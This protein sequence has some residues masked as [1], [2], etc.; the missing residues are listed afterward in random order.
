MTLAAVILLFRCFKPKRLLDKLKITA[1]G[2]VDHFASK[3]SIV[4]G[5]ISS[6]GA[7]PKILP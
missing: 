4:T 2:I 1:D 5:S 3:F 7:N 6:A